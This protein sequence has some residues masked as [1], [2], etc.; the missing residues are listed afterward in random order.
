MRLKDNTRSTTVPPP[1]VFRWRWNRA[2]AGKR[3]WRHLTPA[4][5]SGQLLQRCLPPDPI[6]RMCLLSVITISTA[7]VAFAAAVASSSTD[8]SPPPTLPR[9]GRSFGTQ[10]GPPKPTSS[11]PQA[12]RVTGRA[13]MA[14]DGPR[15]WFRRGG[16]L[17]LCG[18]FVPWVLGM[19][20]GALG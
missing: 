10:I 14:S 15:R 17:L 5:T 18:I 8:L 2:Q 19:L 9:R 6:P 4:S 20:E 11:S 13:G 3:Q 12:E 7:A 16:S 1:S